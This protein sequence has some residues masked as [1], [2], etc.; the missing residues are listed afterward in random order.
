MENKF[1]CLKCGDCCRRIVINQQNMTV[2]LCLLPNE[3]KLFK[4]FPGSVLPYIGLKKI[5]STEIEIVNYQMVIDPCPLLDL[6]TNQ[7]KKYK[8]RPTICKEYPFSALFDGL[9]L[10]NSCSSVKLNYND[11]ECGKTKINAGIVQKKAMIKLSRHYFNTG[12]KL[13]ADKDLRL[14]ILDCKKQEWIGNFEEDYK[15]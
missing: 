1:N 7:C 9:S 8:K 10:E 14:F 3:V 5:D 15:P 4:S 13:Q 12:Q 11:V 2:G 6:I